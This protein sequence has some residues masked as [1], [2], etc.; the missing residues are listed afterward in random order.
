MLVFCALS[1]ISQ[2]RALQNMA[3]HDAALALTTISVSLLKV[4]GWV[5]FYGIFKVGQCKTS[6]GSD[7]VQSVYLSPVLS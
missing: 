5:L 7:L 2:S 3:A 4:E 6:P 1:C